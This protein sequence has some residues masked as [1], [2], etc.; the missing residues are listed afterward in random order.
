MFAP[1]YVFLYTR[2]GLVKTL[3]INTSLFL[4]FN[5]PAGASFTYTFLTPNVPPNF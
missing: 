5:L 1:W 3:D 2:E 4:I